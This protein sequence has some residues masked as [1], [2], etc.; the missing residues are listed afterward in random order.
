LKVK[1]PECKKD[2]T[3]AQDCSCVRCELC[4]LEMDLCEYVIL[5]GQNDPATSDLLADYAENTE[6]KS[7][8]L[9][10]WV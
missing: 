6:G 2:A 8:P 7:E 5:A 10:E 3:L 1:C 9:D 4:E